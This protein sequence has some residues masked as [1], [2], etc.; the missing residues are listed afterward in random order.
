[1]GE[2]GEEPMASEK[3]FRHYVVLDATKEIE[4]QEHYYRE[5]HEAVA[6]YIAQQA[7]KSKTA[8]HFRVIAW[9]SNVIGRPLRGPP[10]T[11]RAGP[12][13]SSLRWKSTMQ[14]LSTK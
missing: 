5:D 14:T 1:M 8:E 2:P 3:K 9:P 13:R 4:L 6:N 11:Y 12:W 10:E 7:F